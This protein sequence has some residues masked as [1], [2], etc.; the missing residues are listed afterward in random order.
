MIKERICWGTL[1]PR[2]TQTIKIQKLLT[3]D[4]VIK[5]GK[6]PEPT[7]KRQNGADATLLEVD[8][9][10]MN[11]GGQKQG[12]HFRGHSRGKSRGGQP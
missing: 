2:L 10:A 3:L 11:R 5:I 6:A 4:E 12:G 8:S 7:G 9:V 1:D